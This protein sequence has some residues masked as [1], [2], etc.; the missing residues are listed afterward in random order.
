MLHYARVERLSRDN[1]SSLLGPAVGG[2]KIKC[3]EY[4]PRVTRGA[5]MGGL[6]PR[7]IIFA[8]SF[9]FNSFAALQHFPAGENAGKKG[10]QG[11]R[12]RIWSLGRHDI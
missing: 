11:P 6:G 4:G 10:R 3:F 2:N 7:E 1:H 12:K 9:C 5:T 8:E